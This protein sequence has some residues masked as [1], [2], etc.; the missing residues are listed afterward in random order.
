MS[1]N[2]CNRDG[3]P[4]L[5]PAP[6]SV[7]WWPKQDER[8]PRGW[9]AGGEYMNICR[10]CGEHFIGDKRAGNC[11]DCAYADSPNAEVSDR[12]GDGARS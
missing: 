6:G 2:D 5:P 1:A 4:A 7:R 9:W 11:A 12:A 10:K 8:P 3:L